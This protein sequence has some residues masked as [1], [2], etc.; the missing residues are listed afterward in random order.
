MVKKTKG[1]Q[2]K[3]IWSGR[4]FILSF[5]IAFAFCFFIGIFWH[6]PVRGEKFND[7]NWYY[8][9]RGDPISWAGVSRAD[10]QVDLPII[11]AP[12]IRQ[13]LEDGQHYD[14]IID[15]TVFLPFFLIMTAAGYYFLTTFFKNQ[16][17]NKKSN[18]VFSI[19]FLILLFFDYFFYFHWFPRI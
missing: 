15:L 19:S 12:F 1:L 3:R 10:K 2:P 5:Q 9:N 17:N 6:H 14:K 13:T 16:I 18:K 4:I 8:I 11:K 7:R